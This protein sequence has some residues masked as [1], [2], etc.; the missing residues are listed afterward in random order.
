MT[1]L[2]RK[3]QRYGLELLIVFLGV[4]LSLLAENW[5][6]TR[7]DAKS[8]SASLVRLH[9][10]MQLDAQDMRLNAS[11]AETGLEAAR[12]LTANGGTKHSADSVSAMLTNIG[13]CSFFVPYTSEY[14]ALKSSGRLSLIS[15]DAI[16]EGIVRLYEEQPFLEWLHERDCLM[17]SDLIDSLVGRFEFAEPLPQRR[18][19]T[20]YPRILFHD[21]Q[22]ALLRDPVLQGQLVRLAT[23]R[24]YLR[25][26]I[27]RRVTS[28]D[29]L[30][31]LIRTE[32][33]SDTTELNTPRG[34]RGRQGAFRPQN[35]TTRS[36]V[37]STTDSVGR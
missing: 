7:A 24:Q 35:D 22:E 33:G 37:P 2:P 19:T 14:T 4:S 18:G 16:R 30:R 5:R 32:L 11:N 15:N 36:G 31:T 29:R 9:G 3:L 21:G 34:G 23:Q 20:R 10:D 28:M 17:T 1:V 8:E 27:Q 12:W 6:Q 13:V 26:Q 25:D